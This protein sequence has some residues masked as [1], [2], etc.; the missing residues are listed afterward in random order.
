MAEH[1]YEYGFMNLF[2]A[3]KLGRFPDYTN[4]KIQGEVTQ[5]L[6]KLADR[7][8][9]VCEKSPDGKTGWTINSH[10]LSA[11]GGLVMIT[12]LLQRIRS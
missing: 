2:I 6:G 3:P 12:I 9:K 5:Q 11:V 7:L 10:S 1:P 8:P 4:P